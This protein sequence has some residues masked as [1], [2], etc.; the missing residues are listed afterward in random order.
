M[1]AWG[2]AELV[3]VS[4]LGEGDWPL[5]FTWRGRRRRVRRIESYEL[6]QAVRQA[7]IDT[8]SRRFR[9]MT[10]DGL[11]CELSHDLSRDRWTME[12]MYASSG[13]AS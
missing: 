11:T 13:G 1:K 3:W 8:A 2:L 9:L 7:S 5:E 4:K 6:S 10:D 12:R